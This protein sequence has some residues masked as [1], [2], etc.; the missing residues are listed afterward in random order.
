MIDYYLKADHALPGKAYADLG[1]SVESADA[2][3]T[4]DE[5]QALSRYANQLEDPRHMGG[6]GK[7]GYSKAQ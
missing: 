1:A 3:P 4:A 2:M 7:F 6:P 5:M